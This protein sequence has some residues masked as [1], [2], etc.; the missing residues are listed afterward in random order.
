MRNV[1]LTIEHVKEYAVHSRLAF[2]HQLL[3]KLCYTLRKKENSGCS[4]HP[5]SLDET[6][7]NPHL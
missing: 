5:W 7:I 2:I 3:G 1:I 4:E 6:L